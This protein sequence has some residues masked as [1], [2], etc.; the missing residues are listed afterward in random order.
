[1]DVLNKLLCSVCKQ[2]KDVIHFSKLNKITRGY[3]YY[4]KEC[5][6]I[7][8][9]KYRTDN[10]EEIRK[11]DREK[12]PLRRDK[13]IIYYNTNKEKIAQRSKNYRSKPNVWLRIKEKKQ[14]Y[15][16]K[17]REKILQYRRQYRQIPK[18]RDRINFLKL[19]EYHENIVENL[20][21]KISSSIRSS[22]KNTKNGNAWTNL[23]NYTVNN[24]KD[25]LASTI[26]RGYAWQD[27]LNGTLHI[28]HIIP[29]RAFFFQS[30]SD[31]GF[32]LCWELNNLRLE[33]K[34]KNISKLDKLPDGSY[35]RNLKNKIS[36]RHQYLF[37]KIMWLQNE[38]LKN[39][40]IDY[41][42]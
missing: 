40:I 2:D 5:K 4:C 6:K 26:P 38:N 17:N 30:Y 42:I 28:E 20:C 13:N 22:L 3:S 31:D 29:K 33:I 15:N 18:K 36:T 11:K 7:I 14:E 34:E 35:A 19:R 37:W 41:C 25:H 24:L 9:T 8:D 32:K 16:K 39:G 10:R 1:M 12:Y 21:R 27:F 23:V